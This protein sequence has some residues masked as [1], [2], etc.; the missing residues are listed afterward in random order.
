MMAPD[1]GFDFLVVGGGVAGCAL[2]RALARAKPAAKIALLEKEPRPA[3]HTSGRNSGVIHAGYNQKPGTQKARLC[4]E[5]NRQIKEYARKREVALEE[6]GIRV[7]AQ[8]EAEAG[9][10]EELLRR[11]TEN[12]V[13]GLRLIDGRELGELEPNVRGLAALDA[14]SGA[15]V[16]PSG[17]TLALA[18]DARA[19]GV[20]I[21]FGEALRR[22]EE[23]SSG[24]RLW[25]S[26]GARRTRFLINCAGLFA[27][28]VAHMAGAGLDYTIVPFR[29]EFYYLD[30]KKAGIIRSMVYGA[31]DVR[32]PFLGIHWTRM[33]GGRVKVGPN[34]VLALG[35]EAYGRYTVSPGDVARMAADPRVW[36][37]AASGEFRKLAARNLKTSLS[38]I[39]FLR[40]ALRLVSGASPSDF[41]RGAP[42]IRAQ[43]VGRDGGMVDDILVERKGRSLHVLN[44]VSP[45]LTCALPFADELAASLD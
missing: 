29:G 23:G 42:G 35:R 7:V 28:R 1:D 34:A 16:D 18:E 20:R 30:P 9:T 15:S 37:M 10:L 14:P 4:V 11:G 27:D 21:F 25:T 33:V 44:W 19:A 13:P 22:L 38:K 26:K 17:L 39:A 2:A 12:G 3:V 8:T 40:E 36:K 43:L 5:G 32:Y 31:P 45:G 24:W 41:T 6:T